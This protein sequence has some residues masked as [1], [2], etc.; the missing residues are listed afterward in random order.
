MFP[1]ITV[2]IMYPAVIPMVC[3]C[4]CEVNQIDQTSV[5]PSKIVCFL[6]V[7]VC[8]IAQFSI[9]SF[10]VMFPYTQP[11]PGHAINSFCYSLLCCRPPPLL[12]SVSGGSVFYEVGSLLLCG[13]KIGLLK[14]LLTHTSIVQSSYAQFLIPTSYSPR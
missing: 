9:F 11:P 1:S 14:L 7:R 5:Q 8:L 10:S 3:V 2:F 4:V 12:C 6:V 13:Q